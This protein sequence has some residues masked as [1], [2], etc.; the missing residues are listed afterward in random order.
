MDLWDGVTYQ[1]ALIV[2]EKS[3]A[4]TI[5]QTGTKPPSLEMNFASDESLNASDLRQLEQTIGK[6]FGLALDLLP[7]YKMASKH[8]RLKELVDPFIGMRPTRFPTSFEA[9]LNAI[10]CQQVSLESG[11]QTLNKLFTRFGDKVGAL[12]ACPRSNILAEASAA[13]IRQL[14]FSSRKADTIRTLSQLVTSGQLNL[15]ALEGL[16]D[17]DAV[18][19][20][21]SIHGI[22]RWSAEYVLLRGLGRLHCFPANDAGGAGK[23]QRWFVLPSRPDRDEVHTL[24]QKWHPYQGLIYF[25]LV[26]NSIYEHGLLCC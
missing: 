12:H 14:G 1:R 8:K 22:G 20:L 2:G 23:L 13:D 21:T 10:A 19:L 26:L 16:A 17:D 11:L 25:H 5:R 6:M 24:L 9:L 7:F 18:A 15:A 3:V 4:V